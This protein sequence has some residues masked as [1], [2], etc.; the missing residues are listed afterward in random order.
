M[1]C[2]LL[3]ILWSIN[4]GDFCVFRANPAGSRQGKV[5]LVQH[6]NFYDADYSGAYSIKEYTS[7]KSYDEFGNWQ[8]EKIELKPLNKDFNP[9]II[10]AEEAEDFRV[11]GE[12]VDVVSDVLTL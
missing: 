3:A 7:V 12:F 1:L 6:T 11:I 4:D 2:K 10:N 5:V 8:H 9:I